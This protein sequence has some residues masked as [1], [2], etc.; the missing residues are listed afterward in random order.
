[1]LV[2]TRVVQVL[3]D[4]GKDR[5]EVPESP[6]L[7]GRECLARSDDDRYM[8]VHRTASASELGLFPVEHP[9]EPPLLW[10]PELPVCVLD[11]G[12]QVLAREVVIDLWQKCHLRLSDSEI[13]R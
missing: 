5:D 3:G 8:P 1:M 10:R 6:F 2:K 12:R 9:Y 7:S 13:S 4:D 11:L